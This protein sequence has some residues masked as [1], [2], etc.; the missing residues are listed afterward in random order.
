MD[1]PRELGAGAVAHVGLELFEDETGVL[2]GV[3]EVEVSEGGFAGED[4]LPAGF[5]G[6]RFGAVFDAFVE[7][8]E[9]DVCECV[10]SDSCVLCRGFGISHLPRYYFGQGQK[11]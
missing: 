1:I 7:D 6:E 5:W 11:T 8:A 2:D 3:V 9:V 4:A 10:G